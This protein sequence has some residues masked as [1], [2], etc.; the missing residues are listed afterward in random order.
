MKINVKQAKEEKA[1][2]S[3]LFQAAKWLQSKGS[4][5]WQGIVKGI[6]NHDTPSAIARGEVYIA[7][8]KE[9]PVG[10]FILWDHQSEW[11]EKLW[12]K[13]KTNN[14]LYLH[15]LTIDRSFSGTGLSTDLIEAA[16]KIGK[17]KNKQGIRL[18]CMA[19]KAYLNQ[20]YQTNQFELLKTVY[21]HDAGEQIAD[22]NLYQFNFDC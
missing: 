2:Q 4:P 15:R 17:L 6:D 20:L 5:Q 22:F 9:K 14:W 11:D 19:D 21:Q 3:L 12:G 1:V 16:K 8:I 13:D 7:E 18:D 10:M